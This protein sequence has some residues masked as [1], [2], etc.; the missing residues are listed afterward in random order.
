MFVW[1]RDDRYGMMHHASVAKM[2]AGNRLRKVCWGHC[3]S[4]DL[5]DADCNVGVAY[6]SN[7]T[8]TINAS[9]EPPHYTSKTSIV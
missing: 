1:V 2:D 4:E 7:K 9:P 3:I 6:P 5:E 8:I